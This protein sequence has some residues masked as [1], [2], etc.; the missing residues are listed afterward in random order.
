MELNQLLS[1]LDAEYEKLVSLN[2][3]DPKFFLNRAYEYAHY[4]EILDYFQN[5]EIDDFNE[6]WRDIIPDN[7]ENIIS[8]IWNSWLNYNHPEYY[9]FFTYEGLCDIMRDY[10]TH[11][12]A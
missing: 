10:F 6:D 5:Q 7:A 1:K 12:Q 9:N 8:G 11:I 3:G 4:N 2:N